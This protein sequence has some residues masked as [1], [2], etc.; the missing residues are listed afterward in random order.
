MSRW[1][2]GSLKIWPNW[3]IFNA[4]AVSAAHVLGPK[5]V[6]L[7]VEEKIFCFTSTVNLFG[8]EICVAKMWQAL[9]IWCNSSKFCWLYYL[10]N[11]YL[12]S[13]KMYQ[14]LPKKLF[15]QLLLPIV[16]DLR[17][18]S[19]RYHMHRRFDLIGQFFMLVLSQRHMSWVQKMCH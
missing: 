1:D 5:N 13:I 2:T 10:T 9:K 12:R 4:C 11:M 17:H 18:V 6:L 15:Y 16:Y 7:T 3:S 14:F 19:L 8:P